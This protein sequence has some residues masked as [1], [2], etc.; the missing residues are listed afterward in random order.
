[1]T[2]CKLKATP[3]WSNTCT[4]WVGAG[5]RGGEAPQCRS[6]C[7][8]WTAATHRSSSAHSSAAALTR[9]PS[10]LRWLRAG[11]HANAAFAA[12]SF[13]TNKADFR[14]GPRQKAPPNDGERYT[15]RKRCRATLE[16]DAH[17]VA[18][19]RRDIRVP[20]QLR[21]EHWPAAPLLATTIVGKIKLQS[22]P[23][24]RRGW[25]AVYQQRRA[26][27]ASVERRQSGDNPRAPVLRARCS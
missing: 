19:D 5:G 6:L 12:L 8:A 3:A 23:R 2:S 17:R 16:E 10:W 9:R 22:S 1:M 11:R 27:A 24:V 4:G 26:R 7:R 18:P 20:S 21:P 14:L 15:I 13:N 25:L